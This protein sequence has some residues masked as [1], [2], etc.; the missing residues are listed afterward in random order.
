MLRSEKATLGVTWHAVVCV[1]AWSAVSAVVMNE[2]CS[3]VRSSDNAYN[4]AKFY[5]ASSTFQ[6]DYALQ[7]QYTTRRR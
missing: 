1:E 2:V 3:V 7:S 4:T 5:S 6:S